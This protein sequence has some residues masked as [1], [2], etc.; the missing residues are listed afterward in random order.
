MPTEKLTQLPG[1]I[2]PNWNAPDEIVA[3]VTT[4]EVGHSQGAFGGFN[5]ATHVGDDEENV[6]L[7][8]AA[9]FGLLDSGTHIQWLD[10][11]HGT[12]V[13]TAQKDGEVRSADGSY[14]KEPGVACCVTTADCLPVFLTSTSGNEIALVHAGWRGL[15]AGIL[16]NSVQQFESPPT[17]LMAWLGPAIGPCHFE[18]GGEVRQAF[19]AGVSSELQASLALSF[20]PTGEAGKFMADLYGLAR[21]WL[22]WLGI[23]NVSGG[24]LCTYCQFDTLYSFRRQSPTGRMASLIYRRP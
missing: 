5:I 16:A 19:L 11:Q 8:R 13:I 23:T 9:L 15:A 2:T 14:T 6:G 17:A 10:Q 21:T 22:N 1:F 7:N 24:N 18:V 4:R 3:L 12:R 20:E